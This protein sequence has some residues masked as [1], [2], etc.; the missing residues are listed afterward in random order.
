MKILFAIL[1]DDLISLENG[2]Y[3]AKGLQHTFFV[4]GGFPTEIKTTVHTCSRTEIEDQ[5]QEVDMSLIWVD[6][7]TG[8]FVTIA[9]RFRLPADSKRVDAKALT[10]IS[11]TLPIESVG[12]YHFDVM[13]D[14]EKVAEVPFEVLDA[15]DEEEY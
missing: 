12:R 13:L 1:A 10:S 9:T 8:R 2:R 3:D 6:E 11:I 15:A 7:Q 5:F 14:G 4:D